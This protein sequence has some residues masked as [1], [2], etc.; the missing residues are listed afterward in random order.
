MNLV[1]KI[2]NQEWTKQK[3]MKRLVILFVIFALCLSGFAQVVQ[4]GIVYKYN[5]NKT[6]TPLSGVS[7]RVNNADEVKSNHKGEFSLKFRNKVQGDKITLSDIYYPGLIIMNIDDIAK[8]TISSEETLYLLLIDEK[9][10][11]D[12][13][14]EN[15]EIATN[16]L[17]QKYKENGKEFDNEYY[18]HLELIDDYVEKITRMD[19]SNSHTVNAKMYELFRMGKL[20]E[21]VSL[22]ENNN[23]LGEY[24][25]ELSDYD[26]L[27]NASSYL[28][29]KKD[30]V[31]S[32]RINIQN[33][34]LS[35]VNLLKMIGGKENFDKAIEL[36][37]NFYE[38]DPENE[39]ATRNYADLLYDQL[40][41][42]EAA[43]VYEKL[44]KSSNLENSSY[45]SLILSHIILL[46][47]NY[48]KTIE[49]AKPVLNKLDSIS[50]VT[51]DQDIYLDLRA[52]ANFILML[53][54]MYLQDFEN[55]I[56]NSHRAVRNYKV[57]S[58][59]NPDLYSS[60]FNNVLS[61]SSLLYMQTDNKIDA[62]A[63]G[64]TAIEFGEKIYQLNAKK[65]RHNLG[66]DYQQ[67]AN[68]MSWVSDIRKAD[69][70]Y[71][72]AENLYEEGYKE[73]SDMYAAYLAQCYQNHAWMF[74]KRDEYRDKSIRPLSKA[75]N[76]YEELYNKQPN[77][78]AFAFALVNSNICS[79][80]RNIDQCEKSI[81]YGQKTLDILKKEN[82][83]NNPEVQ[84]TL[85]STYIDL[86]YD[87]L[88]LD[89]F[90]NALDAINKALEINPNRAESIELKKFTLQ[91]IESL[92]K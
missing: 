46:G 26:N 34:I 79:Y 36:S 39:T 67:M 12:L 66:I 60:Y 5:K 89:K 28:S 54:Y 84:N 43:K 3:Y 14:K 59:R 13:F 49:I 25:T 41:Y 61:Q 90:D 9:E 63:M 71:T 11:R 70:F 85:E 87:Y 33:T 78:Y 57:L 53:S 32:K 48:N 45:A 15:L 58:N 92:K 31:N 37:K 88:R 19:L 35:E 1:T 17:A 10:Y 81:Q 27:K 23:I 47:Y 20:E 8:W 75:L 7:I 2:T 56:Q 82:I 62:E 68:Y 83:I 40:N 69:E 80:Y 77:F 55:A 50:E 18:D 30:E 22:F 91:T 21:A 6:K 74:L 29:M 72:K 65:Y 24:I 42:V 51:K 86:N 64:I 76:L 16:A 4:N 52:Q 73:N 38:V 44:S